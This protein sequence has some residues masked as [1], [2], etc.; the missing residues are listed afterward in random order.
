MVCPHCNEFVPD[1]NYRCPNCRKV[2][3]TEF[4][5][6]DRRT[7]PVKRG[8]LN[9]T[10]FLLI[11]VVVGVGVIAYFL[12]QKSVNTGPSKTD[13]AKS[14]RQMYRP[15]KQAAPGGET[16]PGET[17]TGAA[18]EDA[19]DTAGREFQEQQP[20]E[21]AAADDVQRPGE[22]GETTEGETGETES[23]NPYA[24]ADEEDSRQ[25]VLTHVPGTEVDIEEMVQRGKITIF[26]FYSAYC[27]P[28]VKISPRLAELERKRNDIV[29]VK[30][31]INREGVRGIDWGSPVIKQY[32]IPAIPY[33]IVYDEGGNRTH[34]GDTASQYVYH[35]LSQ[36]RIQ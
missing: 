34:A 8:G 7:G 24:W 26:D 27:G 2:V 5:M 9:F 22:A 12:Y 21:T 6:V 18:P 30:I 36:E 28:C 14:T 25:A 3:K 15:V 4:D 1:A 13:A 32:R 29:V 23:D 31:D 10:H 20:A 11:V 16:T 19:G 17:G 35:L 33:F